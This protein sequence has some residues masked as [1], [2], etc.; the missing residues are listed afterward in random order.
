MGLPAVRSRRKAD[1]D[2]KGD[3]SDEG[4]SGICTIAYTLQSVDGGKAT[5]SHRS[6]TIRLP[7]AADMPDDLLLGIFLHH[8]YLDSS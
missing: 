7:H 3:G 6:L 4:V 5:M 2:K 1:A 8:F